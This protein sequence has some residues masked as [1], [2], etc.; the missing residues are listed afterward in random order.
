M[1][2][3]CM[4]SCSML[5]DRTFCGGSKKRK[6]SEGHAPSLAGRYCH[7]VTC[8]TST[9][10][11][12]CITLIHPLIYAIISSMPSDSSTASQPSSAGRSSGQSGPEA[13][14]TSAAALKSVADLITAGKGMFRFLVFSSST[15][16]QASES[17]QVTP[18]QTAN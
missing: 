18:R 8:R 13:D 16:P 5:C 3:H 4:N 10:A 12:D 15:G 6:Y 17:R 14:R 9:L 11:V 1:N 2:L 7:Y